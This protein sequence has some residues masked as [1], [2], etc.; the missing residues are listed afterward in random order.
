MAQRLPITYRQDIVEEIAA[1]FDL[2]PHNARALDTVVETLAGGYEPAVQQVLHMATGAGKT[3]LMAAFVEYL[4]REGIYNVLVVTPGLVVQSKTVHN[5]QPG[6]AK[7]ISGAEVPALVATPTSLDQLNTTQIVMGAQPSR[8]YVFN[9]QQ[10][11]GPKGSDETAK[12]GAGVVRRGLRRDNEVYGNVFAQLKDLDDLVI[13]ADESHLYGESAAAFNAALVELDP[14]LSLGLTASASKSDHV[15]FRYALYEAI[16]DGCVKTPVLAFR[17]T[18]Y[19]DEETQLRDALALLAIKEQHY[20]AW[21]ESNGLP[22][23]KPILFVTCADTSHAAEIETVL[24]GPSFLGDPDQVLRIDNTTTDDTS[25]RR[26]EALDHPGSTVRAVVSVNMLKEGWDVKN[27]AVLCALRVSKSA[28]LTQQTMGRGLR[29]PYGGYTGSDHVDQLDIISHES[30]RSMLTEENVLQEFGL[31]GAMRPQQ[32]PR[33]VPAQGG[34]SAAGESTN[35][36]DQTAD[37]GNSRDATEGDAHPDEGPGP[38]SGAGAGSATKADA[39]PGA[40]TDARAVGIREIDTE[41]EHADELHTLTVDVHPKYVG[42]TFLFPSTRMSREKVEFA[43]SKIPSETITSAAARVVGADELIEREALTVRSVK[44]HRILS[45]TPVDQA[46]GQAAPVAAAD[47]ESVLL[48]E[49]V[50]HPR[51]PRTPA[52]IGVAKRWAVPTFVGA[53]TTEWTTKSLISAIREM[54]GV[55]VSES[56]RFDRARGTYFTVQPVRLPVSSTITYGVGTSTHGRISSR[57]EFVASRLYEPWNRSLF[58]AVPFDS[59]SG[60]Y[61]FA[62]LADKSSS[63][64]WWKRLLPADDAKIA[65]TVRD[66]YYPDFVVYDQTDGVHWIVEAKAANKRDDPNVAAKRIATEQL[67]TELLGHEQFQDVQWGYFIAYDDDIAKVDSW[68][69]LKQRSS[70]VGAPA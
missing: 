45:T 47:A 31:D 22:A 49:L 40:G 41:L 2:R 39:Q 19:P 4:R 35:G 9:I 30:Y 58:P 44:A 26:L 28:V 57:G 48:D 24:A 38:A 70:L 43:I 64:S 66:D 33:P 50:K 3:Y 11:I 1:A 46:V 27:I 60:E 37:A 12:S 17:K 51:F 23:V 67:V 61:K 8:V 18:G 13:I 54:A 10:L 6:H 65:Y 20:S 25:R 16:E 69:E 21:A 5:F 29:L 56:D 36:S 63:V 32:K 52:N 68:E 59:Y 34:S 14:A 62:E 42:T 53:V 7:Y 55:L 15:I